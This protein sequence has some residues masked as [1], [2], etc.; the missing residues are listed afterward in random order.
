MAGWYTPDLFSTLAAFEICCA[1]HEVEGL[2]LVF[3]ILWALQGPEAVDSPTVEEKKPKKTLHLA[4]NTVT[5]RPAGTM[6]MDSLWMW[7]PVPPVV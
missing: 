7:V 1:A 5:N 3:L 4:G 6:T 2:W